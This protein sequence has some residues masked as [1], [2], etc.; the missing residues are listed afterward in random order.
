MVPTQIFVSHSSKDKPFCDA[1]VAGPRKAGADVWYD[2]HNLGVGALRREIMREL[3]ARAIF[4]VVLSRAAFESDWVQD[5]CEWAYNPY[6]REE[7]RRIVPMVGGKYELRDF[8][9][10]LFLEPMKRI[11]G[12][13][14]HPYSP[15]KATHEVLIEIGVVPDPD[16]NERKVP[17]HATAEELAAEGKR[18]Y[19]RKKYHEAIA[20]CRAAIAK[21]PKHF[22]AWYNLAYS[23][24]ELE[25][26]PE[27]LDA[28]DHAL[29]VSPNNSFA[30]NLK[31]YILGD[32][33][34]H[35]DQLVATQHAVDRN[36]L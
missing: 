12:P 19:F 17:P 29:A 35:A 32:M 23:L 2:E 18:L 28:V 11:E 22:S 20:F 6:K 26:H 8:N 5:E 4:V 16:T 34:R 15:D 24:W 9:S 7:N 30:W 21:N 36:G 14:N 27:A 13:G 25:R 10:L 3:T 31:G 1:L 33:G